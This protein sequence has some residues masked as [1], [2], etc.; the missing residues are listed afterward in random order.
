MN[1]SLYRLVCSRGSDQFGL[2]VWATS[3]RHAMN[4]AKSLLTESGYSV[5]PIKE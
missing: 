1:F 4:K 5:Y 3:A 2:S